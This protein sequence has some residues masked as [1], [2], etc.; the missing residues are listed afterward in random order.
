MRDEILKEA[1]IAKGAFES[2]GAMFLKK[3]SEYE[4]SKQ[5][6][7]RTWTNST[8]Y[9][10]IEGEPQFSYPAEKELFDLFAETNSA[11]FFMMVY[12]LEQAGA[13]SILKPLSGVQPTASEKQLEE[14]SAAPP[15][16]P[17]SAT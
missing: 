14:M 1:D 16:E 7:I 12:G 5:Q 8:L 15:V 4:G 10:F 3:L 2:V 11:K 6:L 13:I 9:P 17:T